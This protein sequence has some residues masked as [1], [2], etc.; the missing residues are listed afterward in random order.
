MFGV[1]WCGFFFSQ[2]ALEFSEICGGWVRE[3]GERG[4]GMC[5]A[6]DVV[7]LAVF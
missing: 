4:G 2:E 1:L 6:H 5:S 3:R 7:G